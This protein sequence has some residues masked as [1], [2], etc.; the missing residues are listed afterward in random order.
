VTNIVGGKAGGKPGA[1]TAI[2]Q[3]T[4]AQ[5]VDEGVEEATRWIEK[6]AL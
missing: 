3:G 6:L 5:K 1:P 2:G 4:N